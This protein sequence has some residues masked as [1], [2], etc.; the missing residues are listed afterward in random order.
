MTILCK[1]NHPVN[2]HIFLI[3]TDKQTARR[4]ASFCAQCKSK[5]KTGDE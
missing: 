1:A 4:S 3:N 2:K 5:M